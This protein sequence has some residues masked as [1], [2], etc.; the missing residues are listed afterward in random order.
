MKH[1][2]TTATV[3]ELIAPRRQSDAPFE[4]T[5]RQL[6]AVDDRGPELARQDAAAGDDELGSIDR[7]LHLLGCDARQR[8]QHE[9]LAL[10][11]QNVDRRLPGWLPRP[12]ARRTKKILMHAFCPGEH[13]AGLRPHPISVIIR[14]NVP[15]RT[16]SVPFGCLIGLRSALFN[17]IAGRHGWATRHAGFLAALPSRPAGGDRPWHDSVAAGARPVRPGGRPLRSQSS[18]SSTA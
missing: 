11:L 17:R 8:H 5:L 3:T 2:S 13:L 12:L 6:E 16:I 1:P 9:H 4:P 14:H 10:G 15:Q 18:S 7:R